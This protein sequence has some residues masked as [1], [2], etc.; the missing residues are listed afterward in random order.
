MHCQLRSIKMKNQ[1]ILR[2]CEHKAISPSFPTLNFYQ[3]F[4]GGQDEFSDQFM[5]KISPRQSSQSY[6]QTNPGKQT[7]VINP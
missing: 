1:T 2:S 6:I 4:L 7:R 3:V 5:N